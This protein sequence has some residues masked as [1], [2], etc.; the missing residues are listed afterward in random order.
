MYSPTDGRFTTKDSWQGDYNRP[1][2]YNAWLYVYAN[3]INLTDPSGHDPW[4]CNEQSNPDLCY[5]KWIIDHGGRPTPDILEAY[6]DWSPSEAL[7]LLQK[8]F[9]IKLPNGFTYRFALYGRGSFYLDDQ[10]IEGYSSW[11]FIEQSMNKDITGLIFEDGRSCVAIRSDLPR[12]LQHFDYSV[13][14]TDKAFSLYDFNPDDIASIM[15]HEGVHAWQES[16]AVQQA[17]PEA[18]TVSF[19]NDNKN[20]LE[21]QAYEMELKLN[22]TRTNLSEMRLKTIDLRKGKYTSEQDSPIILPVGVP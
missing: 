9:N 19:Y 17:G 16:L 14:I 6:Y 22:G 12:S 15:I 5:A 13:Y 10:I 1:M 18:T 11:F 4:W 2:S 7:D 20:A 8:Y 21:L 3:P